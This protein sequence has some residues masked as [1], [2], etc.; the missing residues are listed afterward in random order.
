MGIA[1]FCQPYLWSKLTI[2]MINHI[3]D[4]GHGQLELTMAMVMVKHSEPW[5]W[6]W[7][8]IVDHNQPLSTMANHTLGQT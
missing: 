8:T 2:F 5:S 3:H 6:T 1:I 7:S 4:H